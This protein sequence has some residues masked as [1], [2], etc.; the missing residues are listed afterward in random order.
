M[1]YIRVTPPNSTS[2]GAYKISFTA[3]FLPPDANTTSALTLDTWANGTIVGLG[4]EQWFTFIATAGN[5]YIHLQKG[6]LDDV[7]VQLYTAAGTAVESEANLYDTGSNLYTSRS[8]TSG[9][10]YYIRVRPFQPN[11][12]GGAYKIGFTESTTTP[13][14]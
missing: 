5:Q 14:S 7:Y 13:T 9:S 10:E 11:S 6:T 4:G 1:Y 3:S 12:N 8:V 2:S